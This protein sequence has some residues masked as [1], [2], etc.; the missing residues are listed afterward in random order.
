MSRVHGDIYAN[1]MNIYKI[2]K[3]PRKDFIKL[4][5]NVKNFK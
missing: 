5:E 4:L 3:I 1:G 2:D